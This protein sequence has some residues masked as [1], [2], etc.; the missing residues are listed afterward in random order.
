MKVGDLVRIVQ[1]R[2]GRLVPARLGEVGVIIASGLD[3]FRDQDGFSVV[4]R[5]RAVT[6][7]SDYLEVISE[8]R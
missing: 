1:S 4:I 7:G 3:V 6:F 5:D 8:S 2:S